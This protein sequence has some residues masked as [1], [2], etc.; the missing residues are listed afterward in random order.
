MV[1]FILGIFGVVRLGHGQWSEVVVLLA[2]IGQHEFMPLPSPNRRGGTAD[3]VI[4]RQRRHLELVRFGGH[5]DQLPY[6]IAID[7][8][9]RI[10]SDRMRHRLAVYLLRLRTIGIQVACPSLPALIHIGVEPLVLPTQHRY[11]IQCLGI[12]EIALERTLD[13]KEVTA[14]Q[15][16][17]MRILHLPAQHVIAG[18]GIGRIQ[19]FHRIE[20]IDTVVS[21]DVHL[22][23]LLRSTRH[24]VSLV[25]P[26]G[27]RR[28]EILLNRIGRRHEDRTRPVGGLEHRI[29]QRRGVTDRFVKHH[30]G[31]GGIAVSCLSVIGYTVEIRIVQL[32]FDGVVRAL[33]VLR[34]DPVFGVVVITC[35]TLAD[36]DMRTDTELL[37]C[38]RLE[39]IPV[40][41]YPG[42]VVVIVLRFLHFL[43]VQGAI[44][45]GGD[46][47]TLAGGRVRHLD[48][49][50]VSRLDIRATVT[51]VVVCT[52]AVLILTASVVENRHF[53]SGAVQL[54]VRITL[55]RFRSD[56]VVVSA[57]R[58]DGELEVDT[59]CSVGI[60]TVVT[61]LLQII[62]RLHA[63]R[64]RQQA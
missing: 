39:R 31:H 58:I 28:I 50:D 62:I 64:D 55:V 9:Y 11:H 44:G 60:R 24:T 61:L 5:I 23:C 30:V 27:E 63:R 54:I 59:V 26:R 33:Q 35:I 15:I 45:A 1:L 25:E 34:Q 6:R 17:Q 2:H 56:V 41:L 57:T 16:A 10:R 22:R 4:Y 13:L 52:R 3:T 42:R 20:V 7:I 48:Y 8:P 19:F 53:S 46:H 37:G 18:E 40:H 47:P 38:Q 12:G 51:V 49:S 14:H 43:H 32:G 29:I 21:R 36:I